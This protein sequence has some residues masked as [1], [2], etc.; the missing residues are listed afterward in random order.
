MSSY[1]TPLYRPYLRCYST[2]KMRLWPSPGRERIFVE[3][4]NVQC[5]MY[6]QC[7]GA[8]CVVCRM[9]VSSHLS[10]KT[11][12]HN[13]LLHCFKKLSLG[14]V[15]P[16]SYSMYRKILVFGCHLVQSDTV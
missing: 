15:A 5:I 1:Y 8:N 7:H 10:D 13:V 2:T 11:I 16:T 14:Y 4:D 12:D 6:I 3:T 9:S